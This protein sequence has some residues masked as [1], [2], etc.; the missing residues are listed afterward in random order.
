MFDQ[1]FVGIQID[2]GG[3]V[4]WF[5]VYKDDEWALRCVALPVY[6]LCWVF[7][8]SAGVLLTCVCFVGAGLN[9]TAVCFAGCN[10]T[11]TGHYCVWRYLSILTAGFCTVGW[12]TVEVCVVG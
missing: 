2:G 6:T 3:G 11:M 9:G 10:I 4:V 7:V 8:Q 1:C 12:N 5:A